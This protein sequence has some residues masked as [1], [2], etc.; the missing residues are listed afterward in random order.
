[1]A[2]DTPNSMDFTAG[3][4]DVGVAL[5][6]TRRACCAATG[7][8]SPPAAR[9]RVPLE[10]APWGDSFGMCTDAYGVAWLVNI[11]GTPG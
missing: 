5:A 6:A 1:M 3:Q 4:H 10:K 2:A 7:R 9:S 11:A 8:S